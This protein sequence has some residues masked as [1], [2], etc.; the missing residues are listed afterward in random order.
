VVD[1]PVPVD[2]SHEV[3]EAAGV[4]WEQRHPG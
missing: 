3:E 2:G 4:S 1:P